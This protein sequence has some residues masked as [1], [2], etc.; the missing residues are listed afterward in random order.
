MSKMKKKNRIV[1]ISLLMALVLLVVFYV[2]FTNDKDKQDSLIDNPEVDKGSKGLTLATIDPAKLDYLHLT[3]EGMDIE[4]IIEGEEWKDQSE[5][6][7]P[8]NQHYV[9]NMIDL[10]DVIISQRI[11]N[12]NPGDLAEYGLDKPEV[13]INARE[14][15]GRAITLRLGDSAVGV[16]GVYAQVNEDNNVYLLGNAYSSGFSYSQLDMTAVED[17]P[18]IKPEEIYHVEVLKRDGEDFE[19]LYDPKN[20][21]DIT[22]TGMFPWIILKPY[23]R[24]Y[25]ASGEKVTEFQKRFV[26]FRFLYC[27]DYN[28]KDLSA[29][30]LAD[31]MATV[32]I[33]YYKTYTMK[34][35]KPEIHPESGQELNEKTYYEDLNY[36]I[37][38]GNLND[39]YYYVMKDGVNSVY[40][41]K[42]EDVDTMLDID[43]FDLINPFISILNI[44][45]ADKIVAEIEGNTYIME[46]KRSTSTTEA[47]EE[48][49]TETYYYNGKIVSGEDFKDVYQMIVSPTYDSKINSDTVINTD[50]IKPYLTISFYLN[51]EKGTVLTTSYLPYD[52]SFYLIQKAEEDNRLH[53]F[54]ADKRKIDDIAK[55][56]HNLYEY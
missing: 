42:A 20:E 12:D 18:N 33:G 50:T 21:H 27:V 15:D 5:P 43:S 3:N 53:Y 19:L 32:N 13:L 9:K 47:N 46:I 51:D 54:G 1:L 55:A 41:M 17:A 7:R 35:D 10:I 23:S 49:T 28:S 34:L 40:T 16:D 44:V 22:Y 39:G 48:D 25:S 11:I 31:P 24:T 45:S 6:E 14:S 8:I 36:K 26:K 4:L 30:G 56:I 52:E 37:H 29:Y 38:V 2:W